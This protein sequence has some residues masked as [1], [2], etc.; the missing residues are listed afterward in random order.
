MW[1]KK[2]ALFYFKTE[3]SLQN[4]TEHW[5]NTLAGNRKNIF[6][7]LLIGVTQHVIPTFY[8]GFTQYFIL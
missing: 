4:A 7:W 3:I 5:Q 2:I 1:E 6:K 8:V